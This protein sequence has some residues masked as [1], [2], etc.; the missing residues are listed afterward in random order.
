MKRWLSAALVAASML[1]GRGAHAQPRAVV[2]ALD[3]EGNLRVEDEAV[4]RAAGI[5]AG[6]PL[7]PR[8]LGDAI[9]RVYAL[10]LFEDIVIDARAVGDTITLVFVVT[11][12]PA[13]ESV[14]YEGNR[15]I[16]DDEL[17]EELALRA[18]HCSICCT[19]P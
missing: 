8:V 11:E 2:D 19:R 3:V 13:I 1:L 9:R 16:D 10:E 4:L 14:A 17:E 12:K 15:A 5:E 18:A 6:D 7:S